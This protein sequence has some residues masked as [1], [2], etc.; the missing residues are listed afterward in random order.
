MICIQLHKISSDGNFYFLKKTTSVYCDKQV[1]NLIPA[2]QPLLN[3]SIKEFHLP[4][5][6]KP[7]IRNTINC[8]ALSALCVDM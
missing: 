8:I 1:L 4:L 2:N 7:L 3:A 5:G 6:P